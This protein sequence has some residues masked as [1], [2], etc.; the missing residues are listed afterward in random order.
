MKR[1][2]PVKTDWQ[3]I[4]DEIAI[5]R[6]QL[7]ERERREFANLCLAVAVQLSSGKAKRC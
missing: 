2:V 3:A 5:F 7:V 4:S 6:A 1:I